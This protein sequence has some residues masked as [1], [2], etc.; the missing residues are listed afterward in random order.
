MNLGSQVVDAGCDIPGTV[1]NGGDTSSSLPHVHDAGGTATVAFGNHGRLMSRS[2]SSL[3]AGATAVLET[4]SGSGPPPPTQID[5]KLDAP[6]LSRMSYSVCACH[7]VK[8]DSR[9]ILCPA[10]VVK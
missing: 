4:D 8:Q 2:R 7:Y 3:L 10:T 1:H 9:F 6:A 5:D